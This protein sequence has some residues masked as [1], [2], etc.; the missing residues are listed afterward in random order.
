MCTATGRSYSVQGSCTGRLLLTSSILLHDTLL[1]HKYDSVPSVPA[2]VSSPKIVSLA[3]AGMRCKQ[4]DSPVSSCASLS[5]KQFTDHS[6]AC[7]ATEYSITVTASFT[8]KNL[9]RGSS[10][11][12]TNSAPTGLVHPVQA[13]ATSANALRHCNLQ[14]VAAVPIAARERTHVPAEAGIA[15]STVK[16]RCLAAGGTLARQRDP[17]A[18]SVASL[19]KGACFSN[20]VRSVSRGSSA[21]SLES[22]NTVY[23]ALSTCGGPWP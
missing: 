8:F 17:T 20:A 1:R 5:V 9:K 7:T 10:N 14:S 22:L 3:W 23:R 12:P 4:G 11:R 21:T 19:R 15:L 18:K 2:M 16:K 6:A 13:Q